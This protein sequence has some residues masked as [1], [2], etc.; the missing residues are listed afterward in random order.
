MFLNIR[1]ERVRLRLLTAHLAL[2]S[3]LVLVCGSTALAAQQNFKIGKIEFEGLQRLSADDVIETS[4]LKIGQP[5]DVSVLDVAAQSLIDSGLFKNVA[6]RTHA[7]RDQITIT[8][9]V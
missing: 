2:L 1:S 7:N 8:F 6:Y 3:M 4:T 9:L 5:F